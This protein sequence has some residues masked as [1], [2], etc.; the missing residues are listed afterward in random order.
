MS[1]SLFGNAG[2]R[3]EIEDQFKSDSIF[4][5]LKD[6]DENNSIR[7][8]IFPMNPSE[9]FG[10]QTY[11]ASFRKGWLKDKESRSGCK[12]VFFTNDSQ[13][14]E[15]YD[16]DEWFSNQYG[17]Q[18]PSPHIL[19]VGIIN[20]EKPVI[21]E[22]GAQGFVKQILSIL[23]KEY[24][25]NGDWPES[26]EIEIGR[27]TD[28][29]KFKINVARKSKDPTSRALDQVRYLIDNI[30]IDRMFKNG[31]ILD[32]DFDINDAPSSGRIDKKENVSSRNPED[33]AL[34]MTMKVKGVEIKLKD[35]TID[36]LEK[37]SKYFA[38]NPEK[39]NLKRELV[40]AIEI[41]LTKKKNEN[42]DVSDDD[43]EVP[44]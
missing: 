9:S 27:D 10:G 14:D 24:R 5:R 34:N 29:K 43:D 28:G 22:S 2:S 3:Q 30:D 41:T 6:V 7:V 32:E 40:D 8:R 21:I 35:M 42:F 13:A 19:F 37:A 17:V 39:A 18:R 44:F 20:Q 12:S 16:H 4:F 26:Y 1:K 38:N 36:D 11:I 25:E 31:K 23:D 15:Q 33:I